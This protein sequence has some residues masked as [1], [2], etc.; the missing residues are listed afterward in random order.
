MK[1]IAM[2]CGFALSAFAGMG[3]AA[4]VEMKYAAA[5]AETTPWVAEM[6]DQ[7]QRIEENS[8][9]AIKVQVF[10]GGALGDEVK[11][12]QS[13]RRGR[14]QA[15]YVST[16]PLASIVPEIGVMEAPFLWESN[17]ERDFVMDN[18]LFDIYSELAEDKGLKLLAWSELGSTSLSGDRVIVKP[19]DVKGMRLRIPEAKSSVHYINYL[20]ATPT[21]IPVL[22]TASALQTGLVDGVFTTTIANFFFDFYKNV[23]HISMT[24]GTYYATMHL[25]SKKWFDGLSE[26]QQAAVLKDAQRTTVPGR[27]RLRAVTQ[28][29]AKKIEEAGVTVTYLTPEQRNVWRDHFKASNDEL[30]DLLGGKSREVFETILKAKAEFKSSKS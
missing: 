23:S 14:L 27:T 1:K 17:E 15:A 5:A 28:G 25:V 9:G 24:E 18:Y 16:V 10:T 13:L 7:A 20:G 3:T 19:E 11:L 30:L 8:G 29:L 12:V 2:L 21:T 6:K 22:E 4:A 26:E